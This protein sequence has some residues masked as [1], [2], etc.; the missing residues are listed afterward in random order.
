MNIIVIGGGPAGMIAAYFSSLGGNR[1]ILIE[2]NEKLGKKLYITGKGRCN[3]TNSCDADAF[4][5]NVVT[6]PRFLKS[7]FYGFTPDE[8]M[9]LIESYGCRL[10]VERGNRVFPV[11]DKSG[12]IIKT[13]SGM[14]SR[15][16]VDVHLN[17]AV[18]AVIGKNGRVCGVKTNK[19][20]YSCDK[21]IVATGGVSY[22]LTGSTGD[23]YRFAES[24][25]HKIIPPVQGL[26]PFTTRGGFSSLS[27]LS[28]KNVTLNVSYEGKL[29]LSEFGELLF[30]HQGISGPIVL[31]ASSKINRL[32]A[33]GIKMWIDLKPA[34]DESTLDKRVLRDFEELNNRELKNSLFKLLPS[35]L[36]PEVIL[37]SGISPSK[38]N[39]EISRAERHN[40]V[41]ALKHFTVPYIG[42]RPFSEAIITSG[43]VSVDEVNP[44]TL[45]SKLISGLFFAG[46]VLDVDAL[47]GGFNLHI[48]FSTGVKA[49]SDS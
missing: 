34:L 40:L 19:A 10:K 11:S 32:P 15:A 27:G 1:T 2:K 33:E 47:T 41:Y 36:V 39:S 35:S 23:G 28:L 44:K 26:V 18:V 8:L 5:S 48:A 3:V 4:F 38:R 17:E 6:N 7:S 21:V 45:E 46:E 9:A 43:G 30:T 49:G 29:F 25:G 31:T 16:A 14:L 12:D 24:F 13:F 37:R 42:L 22:P 20:S